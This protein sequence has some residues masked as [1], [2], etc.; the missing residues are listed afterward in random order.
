MSHIMD[1]A[2]R[3]GYLSRPL[4]DPTRE[5][6]AENRVWTFFRCRQ[7]DCTFEPVLSN[8]FEFV[9]A[10][11][12]NYDQLERQLVEEDEEHCLRLIRKELGLGDQQP[13]WYWDEIKSGTY[14]TAPLDEYNVPNLHSVTVPVVDDDYQ[15]R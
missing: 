9:V 7:I 2:K 13:K 6:N 5:S 11:Y 3:R 15:Q 4:D 1:C 8:D 14:Y 10:L 12:S